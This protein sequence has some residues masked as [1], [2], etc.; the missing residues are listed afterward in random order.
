[1]AESSIDVR[2]SKREKLYSRISFWSS[3]ILATLAIVLYYERNPPDTEDI[4]KMRVFF[5]ENIMEVTQF[6]K[7]TPE[8]MDVN[9]AMHKH[10]FYKTFV[11]ASQ[12]EQDRIRALIHVSIDYSSNAYWFNLIFAWT[13]VFTTLWFLGAITEGIIVLVRQGKN[14]KPPA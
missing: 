11:K 1:M 8:E 3:L 2:D 5:S 10:P 9:A 4:K 6:I 12:T 7:L 13:V 14:V